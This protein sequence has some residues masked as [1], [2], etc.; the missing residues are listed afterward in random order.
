MMTLF[1]ASN[2]AG[3][4]LNLGAVAV[5]HAGKAGRSPSWSRT[6][7]ARSRGR[8]WTFATSSSSRR[9]CSSGKVPRPCDGRG[10][11]PRCHIRKGRLPCYGRDC[12][13]LPY[14]ERAPATI[15]KGLP[16]AAIFGKG[17]RRRG[18]AALA[19]GWAVPSATPIIA[20]APIPPPVCKFHHLSITRM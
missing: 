5:L 19:H 9:W 12:P 13:T 15:R 3:K 1:S 18:P 4:S 2:Y 11:S 17:G 10:W 8:R 14:S 20:P 6:R 16:R 7:R